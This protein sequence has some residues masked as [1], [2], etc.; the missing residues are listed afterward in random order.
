MPSTALMTNSKTSQRH[1]RSQS[2]QGSCAEQNGS[3]S[4]AAAPFLP[5]ASVVRS[6][7]VR[8]GQRDGPCM[9]SQHTVGHV[10][11][12]GVL[13]TNLPHV[14]PGT[15]ALCREEKAVAKWDDYGQWGPATWQSNKEGPQKRTPSHCPR[16]Q[17]RHTPLGKR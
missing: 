17:R 9:V 1:M 13:S 8:K 3:G 16:S 4:I 11:T 12:V 5:S 15:R 7:P 14:R 10:Y 6:A 2:P